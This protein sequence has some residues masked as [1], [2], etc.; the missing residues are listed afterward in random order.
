MYNI[1]RKWSVACLLLL[2][3]MVSIACMAEKMTQST[4]EDTD[5]RRHIKLDGQDNF[6]DLG[7]YQTQDGRH[8][9]WGVI[10]RAGQLSKLSD[11]DITRLKELG[12]RTVIDFRG[13]DELQSRGID[14]LP[15]DTRFIHLPIEIGSL[16]RME[17][18]AV[19]SPSDAKDG[20]VSPGTISIEVMT[21]RIML[22]HANVYTTLIR[23][24]ADAQNRPLL[25]HCTAGKD[26]TG[27]GGAVVLTLLGV[28]WETVREDY[29]LSNFYRREENQRELENLRA[30]MAKSRGIPLEEVDISSYEPMYVVSAEYID[31]ARDAAI[32][33]YGSM[34]NYI[35]EGLGIPDETVA[36][37]RKELLQ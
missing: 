23:E 2:V 6:R 28:P 34:E 18:Q 10:Y 37:L 5:S 14:R 11:A 31:A 29:L 12:I 26:R 4:P 27:V 1:Y 30:G 35:S 21:E 32:R 16:L 13:D 36:K 20:S 24:L 33:K 15:P 7:G 17:R 25:F 19:T 9:K 3:A 8:V 22:E